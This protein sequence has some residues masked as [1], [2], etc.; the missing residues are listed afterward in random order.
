MLWGMVSNVERTFFY[1]S[2]IDLS[3]RAAHMT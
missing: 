2:R 1:G 3:F